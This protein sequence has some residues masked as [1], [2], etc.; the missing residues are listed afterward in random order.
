MKKNI[1]KTLYLLHSDE[2]PDDR[3]GNYSQSI[4]NAVAQD[5]QIIML[6]MKSNNEEKY[7]FYHVVV[8]TS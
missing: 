8:N 3:N 2:M 7:T 5:P 4:D 6:V 1:Y